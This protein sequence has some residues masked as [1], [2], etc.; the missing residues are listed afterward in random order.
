MG[1]VRR[2][3][4][5]V[6]RRQLYRKARKSTSRYLAEHPY[7]AQY[8]PLIKRISMTVT[9]NF[10]DC[11]ERLL[12][13]ADGKVKQ[14]KAKQQSPGKEVKGKSYEVLW[15]P[16]VY[17]RRGK[18]VIYHPNGFLPAGK[19]EPRSDGLVFCENEFADQLTESIAGR[20]ASLLQFFS[21]H[22][23]LLVG[24]SLADST[25]KYLLRQSARLN[26]GHYH[27]LVEFED[28]NQ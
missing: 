3:W 6:V 24:L 21:R 9:Y 11:L 16:D 22:T 23:C 5:D 14:R 10:D 12:E 26:P 19:A 1:E 25:L 17:P 20:Y 15:R 18:G 27:Y 13:E 2:A 28:D 7:L 8:L 4:M